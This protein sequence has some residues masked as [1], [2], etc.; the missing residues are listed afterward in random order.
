MTI[1]HGDVIDHVD[2]AEIALVR[3][4]ALM[5]AYCLAN[6]AENPNSDPAL[7]VG[8]HDSIKA[9][10][11]ELMGQAREAVDRL[12]KAAMGVVSANNGGGRAL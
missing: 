7:S 6:M 5:N 1:S 10:M 8:E 4:G 12:E 2:A 9:M 11:A 3:L